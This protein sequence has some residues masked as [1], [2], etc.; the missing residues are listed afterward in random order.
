MEKILFIYNKDFFIS[1]K[2][3]TLYLSK[4]NKIKKI[5][6]FELL[7][8]Y[9]VDMI[10]INNYN[11]VIFNWDTTHLYKNYTPKQKN[12]IKKNFDK[13]LVVKNKFIILENTHPKT[14]KSVDNLCSLLNENRFVVIFT[15]NDNDEIKYIKKRLGLCK[16]YYIPHHIDIEVFKKYDIEFNE[17]IYDILLYGSRNKNNYPFADRLFNL[18][19]ANNNKFNVKYINFDELNMNNDNINNYIGTNLS[20]LL[21]QSKLSIVTKSKFDYLSAKYFEIAASNCAIIGDLPT[22]SEIFINKVIEISSDMDDEEIITII[23]LFI[24]NYYLLEDDKKYLMNKINSEFNLDKYFEKILELVKQNFKPRLFSLC[25]Y[26][27][28]ENYTINNSFGIILDLLILK[29]VSYKITFDEINDLNKNISNLEKYFIYKYEYVPKYFIICDNYF[30]LID[31]LLI[32]ELSKITKIILVIDNNQ[33]VCTSINNSI[34]LKLNT[35]INKVYACF[36]PYTYLF[37][38]FNYPIIKNNILFPNFSIWIKKININ[39]INKILLDYNFL[40]FNQT[41]E[42][43]STLAKKYVKYFDVGISFESIIANSTILKKK[44]STYLNKYICCIVDLNEDYISSKVFEICGSGSLLLCV[45]GKKNILQTH[46]FIDG[47]NYLLCS[48]ENIIE[49]ITWILNPLNIE[50]V[51]FIRKRGQELIIKSHTILNR[52]NYFINLLNSDNFND[53][54]L[55]FKM[56]YDKI[57]INLKLGYDIYKNISNNYQLLNDY[58]IIEFHQYNKYNNYINEI[59]FKIYYGNKKIILNDLKFEFDNANY[60]DENCLDDYI[61][62]ICE[63]NNIINANMYGLFVYDNFKNCSHFKYI[64]KSLIK[65]TQSKYITLNELKKHKTNLKQFI[66]NKYNCIPKYIFCYNH[67]EDFDTFVE[68]IKTFS[69]MIFFQDNLYLDNISM[70]RRKNVYLHTH[71]CFSTY[72]Y[73]FNLTN[74]PEPLNHYYFPHSSAYII[75]INPEPI[76]KIL[77]IEKK[78]NPFVMY[79]ESL[80]FNKSIQYDTYL[81][82]DEYTHYEKQIFD[83]EYY[84]YLN[85]YLCVVSFTPLNYILPK[86]FEICGAGCLLLSFNYD[87][88]KIYEELGFIDNLNYISCGRRNCNEKINWI[89]NPENFD[90][91]NQIRKN[92]QE[93][94]IDKHNIEIRTNF[95]LDLLK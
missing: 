61:D 67:L 21:N 82:D 28:T 73:L 29:T 22:C 3:N 94:M 72:K 41:H 57:Q 87:M 59:L 70:I 2:I 47:D 43:L 25:I 44:Y 6:E 40:S 81:Y 48:K 74:M 5:N 90:K 11:S 80:M 37:N 13:L 77:L 83:K 27:N 54:N 39:P 30:E 79:F 35:I 62:C 71:T 9:D 51:N 15:Y 88:E 56:Q 93:L 33:C 65:N 52:Y 85:K 14:Y 84:N 24:K 31:I 78:N 38:K 69:K 64:F 89:L 1:E 50:H 42:Y 20:K 63:T 92:G 45:N 58:E 32:N 36:C 76:M 91:V 55:I 17:K 16:T 18:I 86:V 68:E 46:G 12:K 95:I 7:N 53:N 75:K 23:E 60:F 26:G 34:D 19:L 8:I 10:N 4:I 49:K 66:I